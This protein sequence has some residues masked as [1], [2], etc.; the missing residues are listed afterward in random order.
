MAVESQAGGM[1]TLLAD[2][3]VI[4]WSTQRSFETGTPPGGYHE[5]GRCCNAV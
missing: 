1:V 2:Q 4:I 5:Q 3:V